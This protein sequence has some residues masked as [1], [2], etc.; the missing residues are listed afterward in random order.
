MSKLCGEKLQD[1]KSAELEHEL[2]IVDL[3]HEFF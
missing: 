1:I 3:R 2:T